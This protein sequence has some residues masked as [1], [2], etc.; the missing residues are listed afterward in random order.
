MLV[1]QDRLGV[2]VCFEGRYEEIV[3]RKSDS[4]EE[5]KRA[6]IRRFRIPP[7]IPPAGEGENPSR[8]VLALTFLGGELQDR[9]LLADLAVPHH[10]AIKAFLKEVRSSLCLPKAQSVLL[11]P[12]HI[13]YSRGHRVI[14][15]C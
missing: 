12:T 6:T 3:M 11:R 15:D 13:F 4:V 5:L 7:D 8:Q 1:S 14:S 9:T 10:A 2:V